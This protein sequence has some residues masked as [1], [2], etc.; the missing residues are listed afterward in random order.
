MRAV[1]GWKSVLYQSTK[2]RAELK[3]SRH[4]PNCTNVQPFPGLFASFLSLIG[5]E[6]SERASRKVATEELNKRL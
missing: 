4:S 5:N 2:H 1:I 3:L 6:I